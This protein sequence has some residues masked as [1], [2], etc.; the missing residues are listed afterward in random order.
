M[1]DCWVNKDAQSWFEF[2]DDYEMNFPTDQQR[3]VLVGATGSGKTQAAMWHLARRDY[4]ERPWIVYDFKYD[5]LIGDIENT[6]EIGVTSPIPDKAGLYVVHPL[7]DE[8][9]EKVAEQMKQI[10]Q[11]ENTGVVVDEA[12]ML[13]NRNKPFRALLTQGRSKHIP[14][15]VASQRPVWVDRFVFSEASFYQ[16]FRLQHRKDLMSVQE[17]IP[18]DL[19]RRLP[20][21]HSYYYDVGADQM[22]VLKAV[23]DRDVILDMFDAKLRR[24][25]KA[26]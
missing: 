13:G 18:F 22:H 17:F 9:E 2:Q 3:L 24:V 23:P 14:M 12:Y 1:S 19:S 16:V 21:Y 26:V 20:E 25:R 4:D 15:I 5:E 8:D 7:P 6:Q 11:R 10:W